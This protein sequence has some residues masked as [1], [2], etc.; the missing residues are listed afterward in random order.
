MRQ[1]FA[2]ILI[3]FTPLVLAT[4]PVFA[5][6]GALKREIRWRGEVTRL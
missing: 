1:L 4:Q 6:I 3:F 5:V 2:L